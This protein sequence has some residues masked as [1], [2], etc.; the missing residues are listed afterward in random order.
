MNKK[1]KKKKQ[2]AFQNMIVNLLNIKEGEEGASGMDE[3][4]NFEVT[5][6]PTKYDS[7][8]TNDQTISGSGIECR[9]SL[10]LFSQTNAVR[11]LM[12]RVTNSTRFEYAIQFLIFL[13]SMKLVWDTYTLTYDEESTEI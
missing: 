9:R 11:I 7:L 2:I 10:Y 12:F 13:S 1:V 4:S 6:K 8:T 3:S 5:A